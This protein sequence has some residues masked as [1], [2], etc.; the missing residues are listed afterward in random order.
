M[1]LKAEQ[2]Q[3]RKQSALAFLLCAAV[4]AASILLL[5]RWIALPSE[6][7]ARLAFAIQTSVVHFIVLLLAIRLVSSGR[8]RSAADI[9]GSAKGPPS[10]ALAVKAAFLQNTL[11]QAFLGVGAHLALA[12]IAGGRWLALLVASAILFAIGRFSFYRRYPDGAG[13]RAFGMA[14]TALASLTCYVAALA[15]FISSLFG[16]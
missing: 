12:S 14:T 15:L 4:F 9:G 2:R 10:P 8:Y 7:G 1:D 3:V 6:I 16:G 13:A 11:E 5:P